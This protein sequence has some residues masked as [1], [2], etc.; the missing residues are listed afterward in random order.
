MAAIA[1]LADRTLGGGNI[2]TKNNFALYPS[3]FGK[4]AIVTGGAEGIGAAV[5]EILAI[6][7]TKVIIADIAEDSATQMIE[8]VKN[9]PK[10]PYGPE[11]VAPVF[12]QSDVTKHDVLKSTVDRALQE[13]RTE[14]RVAEL[15]DKWFG[16][17][18]EDYQ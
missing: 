18:Q 10:G 1:E 15:Q 12:Y 6:Q 17:V 2:E 8:K 14:G 11:P 9:T 13:L 5:V 3:L 16:H 7:G 4:T